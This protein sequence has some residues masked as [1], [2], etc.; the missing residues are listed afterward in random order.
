MEIEYK[1]FVIIPKKLKMSLGKACSQTAHATFMAIENQKN[2]HLH[3]KEE[4]FSE[5]LDL[6]KTWKENGMC[7]IVLQCD[8]TE[9]LM[10]IA[11]YLE[12]WKVPHHLYIDEG[13]TEVKMG[14]PTCLATGVITKDKYWMFETLELYK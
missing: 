8:T 3:N 5:H 13:L 14:T 10:G 4:D 9:Q 1:Q 11:K 6:I 2:E 7:V 12:Q